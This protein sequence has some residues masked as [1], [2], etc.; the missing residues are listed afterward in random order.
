MGAKRSRCSTAVR[1][2]GNICQSAAP[3]QSIRAGKQ[4]STGLHEGR[5]NG[6]ALPAK[7]PG[8]NESAVE[9]ANGGESS[10]KFCGKPTRT[11]RLDQ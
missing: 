9:S 10:I 11:I 3:C 8:V 1:N 6:V 4:Y 2:G 5:H 7:H